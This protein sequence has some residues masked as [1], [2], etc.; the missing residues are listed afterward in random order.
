MVFKQH[1]CLKQKNETIIFDFVNKNYIITKQ[2][3]SRKSTIVGK[4][5]KVCMEFWTQ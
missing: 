5:K 3:H 4:K 2:H 1:V